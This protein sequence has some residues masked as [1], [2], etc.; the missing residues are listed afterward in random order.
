MC[1]VAQQTNCY[2]RLDNITPNLR[3]LKCEYEMFA[4]TMG[5]TGSYNSMVL[6]VKKMTLCEP[7][8]MI[9]VTRYLY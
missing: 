7:S 8:W 5:T 1:R 4:C 6:P 3:N 9:N 2:S